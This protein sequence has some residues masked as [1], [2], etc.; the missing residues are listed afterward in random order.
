MT[1]VVLNGVGPHVR[2]KTRSSTGTV[3]VVTR[4]AVKTVPLVHK[5]T[6]VKFKAA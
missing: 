5:T 3:R 1:A 4:D 2:F 6:D